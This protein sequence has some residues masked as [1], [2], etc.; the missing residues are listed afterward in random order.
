MCVLLYTCFLFKGY[1]DHRDLHYPLRRQRQMCIRDRCYAVQRDVDCTKMLLDTP[2]VTHH[3]NHLGQRPLHLASKSGMIQPV[4]LLLKKRA[5]VDQPDDFGWT[6][7]H[8][9]ADAGSVVVIEEL[10]DAG[11]QMDA[12]Q[13][14]G[15]TALHVAA[16][17]CRTDAVAYLLG[18][19]EIAQDVNQTAADG[20][21]A[22]HEACRAGPEPWSRI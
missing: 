19:P 14:I 15:L 16:M 2:H 7:L 10:R 6:A 4:V 22:L 8:Y 18:V 3:A 5:T 21:T 1:G 13:D 11:A 9:A 12:A 17:R 20:T